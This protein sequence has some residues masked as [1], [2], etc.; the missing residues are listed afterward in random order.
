MFD[1]AKKVILWTGGKLSDFFKKDPYHAAIDR[2]NAAERQAR[3]NGEDPATSPACIRAEKAVLSF[4]VARG[5]SHQP[6]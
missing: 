5:I 3:A 4:E 6:K 1:S 2:L